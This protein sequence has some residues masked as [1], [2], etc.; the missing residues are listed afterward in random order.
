MRISSY[1]FQSSLLGPNG[2]K[3]L[4]LPY[5]SGYRNEQDLLH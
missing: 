3:S 1:C 4:V 2:F 5:E